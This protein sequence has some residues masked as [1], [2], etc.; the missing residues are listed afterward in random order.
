MAFFTWPIVT[1]I[2]AIISFI[3]WLIEFMRKGP[4]T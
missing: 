2:T 3:K 4:H 1:L